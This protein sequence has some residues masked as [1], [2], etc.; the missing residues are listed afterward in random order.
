MN[1]Y[2]YKR[3]KSQQLRA[4][5][6]RFEALYAEEITRF[7]DH[8]IDVGIHEEEMEFDRIAELN[9]REREDEEWNDE[10][11]RRAQQDADEERRDEEFTDS[12]KSPQTEEEEWARRDRERYEEPRWLGDCCC[13][14]CI[15]RRAEEVKHSDDKEE[16]SCEEESFQPKRENNEEDYWD[17]HPPDWHRSIRFGRTVYG[18]PLV[19]V[20]F[21]RELSMNKRLVEGVN[22]QTITHDCEL[23]EDWEPPVRVPRRW[24]YTDGK[25]LPLWAEERNIRSRWKRALPLR[26]SKGGHF[27]TSLYFSSKKDGSYSAYGW[28]MKVSDTL[29]YHDDDD[30]IWTKPWKANPR[31][32]AKNHRRLPDAE[33]SKD[34]RFEDWAEDCE[35]TGPDNPIAWFSQDVLDAV[36]EEDRLYG[37]GRW[38]DSWHAEME[39]FEEF[40]YRRYQ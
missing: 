4:D 34:V 16:W 35:R 31:P 22:Q 32:K 38:D 13:P 8:M 39:Q 10:F 24:R 15:R 2:E 6:V 28:W 25:F 23:D 33:L 1:L 29:E 30:E 19:S 18:D 12:L 27:T 17:D 3:L 14:H 26:V 11:D 7:I 5:E 40:D 37:S 20:P 36:D 9:D 21:S